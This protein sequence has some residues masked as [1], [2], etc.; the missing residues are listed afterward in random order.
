M[1]LLIFVLFAFLVVAKAGDPVINLNVLIQ[2][3]RNES[4]IKDGNLM[5]VVNLF[6]LYEDSVT[7]FVDE[8]NNIT[9]DG[10]STLISSINEI[11]DL[12]NAAS[13]SSCIENLRDVVELLVELEGL[14][15]SNCIKIEDPKI[16]ALVLE[17]L[18]SLANFVNNCPTNIYTKFVGKNILIE[19]ESIIYQIKQQSEAQQLSISSK[20]LEIQDSITNVENTRTAKLEELRD[21]LANVNAFASLGFEIIKKQIDLCGAPD[22]VLP[23]IQ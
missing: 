5:K 23:G 1:Q 17:T 8:T 14:S 7:K 18:A 3:Q 13:T 21:C 6:N 12:L 19:G 4:D 15:F 9:N 20:T 22:D 16:T 10:L 2:I 11:R